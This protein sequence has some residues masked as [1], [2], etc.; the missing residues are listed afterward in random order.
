MAMTRTALWLPFAAA[1]LLLAACAMQESGTPDQEVSTFDAGESA[2]AA[3][4]RIQF[5]TNLDG[6]QE[7]PPVDTIGNG[8]G[9]IFLDRATRKLLWDISFN[10]LSSPVTA[11]HFH[12]PVG[13]GVNADVQLP[14]A[15]TNAST[16]RIQG[17]ALLT[18]EQMNQVLAGQWYV[19][20]HTKKHPDGEIRGQVENAGM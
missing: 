3:G 10:D 2:A 18:E 12:G 19:N 6:G 5:V 17:E 13:P 20:I 14:M 8:S 7:T 16:N 9:V 11:A 15:P 4:D 1:S